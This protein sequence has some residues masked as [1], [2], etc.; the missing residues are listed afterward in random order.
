MYDLVK[1]QQEIS[2]VKFTK[3]AKAN[4]GKY[5]T[6]DQ[7]HEKA[8]PILNKNNLCWVTLPSFDADTGHPTLKYE[9]SHVSGY[10]V[11]GEMLLFLPK[12]DP[13]G[14]GS[15]IT[16][17]K[18]YAICA[19]LGITADEDDDGQ[20]AT[21]TYKPSPKKISTK[22]VELLIEWAKENGGDSKAKAIELINLKAGVD[23]FSKMTVTEA[24]ELI[25]K[26]LKEK[27]EP[28]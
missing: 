9:L 23:D 15:A 19:V 17:A 12:Q 8:I 24:S 11:S 13:Q 18:R 10:N 26:L 22:Q 3:D 4:Y 6:L 5:I 27:E 21:K 1:A 20:H 25:A 28:F 14:Q 7:I 16:Y 2:K